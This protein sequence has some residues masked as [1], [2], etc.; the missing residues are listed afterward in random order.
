MCHVECQLPDGPCSLESVPN[1]GRQTQPGVV[2]QQAIDVGCCGVCPIEAGHERLTGADS[3]LYLYWVSSE[4]SHA[5][6]T[7]NLRYKYYRIA[8]NLL[9]ISVFPFHL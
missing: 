7:A 8:L 5:F 2:F 4:L 6:D 3:S 1:V 9:G